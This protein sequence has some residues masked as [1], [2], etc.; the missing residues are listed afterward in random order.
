MIT[1]DK[2]MKKPVLIITSNDN[3]FQPSFLSELCHIIKKTNF[4]VERVIILDPIKK[5]T[6]QKYLIKNIFRL[7]PSEIFKLVLLKTNSKFIN[8]FLKKKIRHFSTLKIIRKNNLKYINKISINENYFYN[9][10]K[11]KKYSFIINTADQIFSERVIK[12]SKYKIFNVHLSLLPKYAGVWTMFQQIS[13]DEKFTG[14][15][16][17]KINKNIDSGSIIIQKKFMLNKKFSLFENYRRMSVFKP[18]L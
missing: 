15:S 17:H 14:I 6:L 18:F 3:Y 5:L 7:Y 13:E 8:F 1:H 12:I 2:I 9:L 10:I 16:I 4:Y 11:S